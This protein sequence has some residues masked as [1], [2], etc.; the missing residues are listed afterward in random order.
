MHTCFV[1]CFAFF[2][3]GTSSSSTIFR[4]PTDERPLGLEEEAYKCWKEFRGCHTCEVDEQNTLG[5]LDWSSATTVG[6]LTM[7]VWVRRVKREFVVINVVVNVQ[8]VN[9]HRSSSK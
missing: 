4:L 3:T 5:L 1:S 6:F 7:A 8:Q 9:A 2:V